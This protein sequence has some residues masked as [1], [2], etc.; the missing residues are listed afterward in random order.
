MRDVWDAPASVI[1]QLKL[2][3][4]ARTVGELGDILD[5]A[6][7]AERER[8][9]DAADAP[10][11]AQR[12]AEHFERWAAGTG[13]LSRDEHGHAWQTCPRCGAQPRNESGL[14]VASPLKRW[15]CDLHRSEAP[16]GDLEIWTSPIVM[17]AAGMIDTEREAIEAAQAER[18]RER[19]EARR[20]AQ[21]AEREAEAAT[22][23]ASNSSSW[24]PSG[25][26]WDRP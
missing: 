25:R 4:G 23:P 3:V 11:Q 9:I 20:A 18:E 19:L 26:G 22:M 13:H 12:Q 1:R 14:P 5:R 8:L 15:W 24:R 16:P 21:Q 10:L 6:T 17:S 2:N 7:P